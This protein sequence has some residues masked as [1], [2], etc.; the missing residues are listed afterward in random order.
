MTAE[1]MAAVSKRN[2]EHR[3]PTDREVQRDRNI[4]L[5]RGRCA[6]K[7]AA[8]WSKLF[9]VSPRAVR[10]YAKELGETCKRAEYKRATGGKRVSPNAK[11][12]DAE[13]AAMMVEWAK[14]PIR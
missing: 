3:A 5:M 8:G 12:A 10:S 9:G 6:Q 14:R 13:Q 2:L 4:E 1:Q 11:D 7:T